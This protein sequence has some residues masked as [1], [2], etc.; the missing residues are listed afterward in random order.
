[1]HRGKACFPQE[2]LSSSVDWGLLEETFKK[3]ERLLLLRPAPISDFIELPQP[4]K[5]LKCRW[6]HVRSSVMLWRI[7]GTSSR[8]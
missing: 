1:M 6:S 3:D 7:R 4:A 2:V 5:D 8:I